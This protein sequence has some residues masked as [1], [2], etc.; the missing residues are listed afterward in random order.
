MIDLTEA[1]TSGV[2]QNR[3]SLKFRKFHRKHLSQS[4]FYNKVAGLLKKRLW[5]RCF[6]VNFAKFLKTSFFREHLRWLLLT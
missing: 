4:L 2:P 3:Y 5:H 6:H 1:A